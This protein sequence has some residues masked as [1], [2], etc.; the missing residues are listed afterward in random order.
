MSSDVVKAVVVEVIRRLWDRGLY[1]DNVWLKQIH[2]NWI[3]EWID[4]KTANTMRD[5]DDQAT[6]IRKDWEEPPV[7]PVFSERLDGETALGGPMQTSHP[8]LGT[9]DDLTPED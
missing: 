5:V 6:A 8:T 2:D 7:V 3:I 1:R 9:F 4:W